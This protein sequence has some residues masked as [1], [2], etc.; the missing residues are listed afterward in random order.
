MVKR[1]KRKHA[2]KLELKPPSFRLK[3]FGGLLPLFA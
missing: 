1:P 2:W 3:L